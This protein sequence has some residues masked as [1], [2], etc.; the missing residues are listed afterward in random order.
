MSPIVEEWSSSTVLMNRG[1]HGRL[2]LAD[3]EA[4]GLNRADVVANSDVII[5]VLKYVGVR[6]TIDQLCVFVEH[7]FSYARPRGK[8]PI[9][10]FLDVYVCLNL[11]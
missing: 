2:V 10:R 9:S 4:K 11:F 1:I 6:T 8:P 7:F 3:P 5:P